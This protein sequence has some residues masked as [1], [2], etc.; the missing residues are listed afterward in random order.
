ML[1]GS[2]ESGGGLVFGCQSRGCSVAA[3]VDE[4]QRDIEGTKMS[5]CLRRDA[6]APLDNGDSWGIAEFAELTGASARRLQIWDECG[7]LPAHKRQGRGRNG[8][9]RVYRKNQIRKAIVLNKMSASGRERDWFMSIPEAAF[10]LR[11]LLF[12]GTKLIAASNHQDAIIR[13][14]VESAGGVNLF[15]FGA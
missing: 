14:G 10:K 9:C 13:I 15:D 5:V 2:V 11:Y 3:S 7:F 8:Y 1:S 12:S 4:K 6:A